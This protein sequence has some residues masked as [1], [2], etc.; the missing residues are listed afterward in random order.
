MSLNSVAN[1][2]AS[3][4]SANLTA[5]AGNAAVLGSVNASLTGTAG[6]ANVTAGSTSTISAATGVT[7]STTTSGN[8]H[9]LTT[10]GDFVTN[11]V[12]VTS[13]ASSTNSLISTNPSGQAV[14]INATDASGGINLIAGAPTDASANTIYVEPN[15]TTFNG[16]QQDAFFNVA[17]QGNYNLIYAD[18]T[19]SEE[20]VGILC[21][22]NTTSATPGQ[23][24]LDVY[25]DM[26]VQG[27]GYGV[28][29]QTT[30]DKTYKK[31]I[32]SF[33]NNEAL[34]IVQQ[35]RPVKYN[36]RID[37]YP[38]RHFPEKSDLGFIAQEVQQLLPQVVNGD[39]DGK[40]TVDYARIVAVLTGA[41][42]Q[43]SNEVAELKA[44]LKQ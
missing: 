23:Y 4:T 35:L 2:T 10:V 8:V 36:W 44:Q 22:P 40:Y 33:D 21:I 16:T 30:S 43:L 6:T 38:E 5:S 28:S 3:G 24:K 26:R 27:T 11:A 18:P 13:T 17:G 37:E 25:G 29:W 41:I 15:G 39:E 7:I 1:V 34:Q 31:D 42:Q 19:T 14:M 20:S 9:V 12:N 32:T